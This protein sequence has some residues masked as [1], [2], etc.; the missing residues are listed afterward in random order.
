MFKRRATTPLKKSTNNKCID[1][2][3]RTQPIDGSSRSDHEAIRRRAST[4]DESNDTPSSALPTI[5]DAALSLDECIHISN[6]NRHPDVLELI[7][8]RLSLPDDDDDADDDDS[9]DMPRLSKSSTT[10]SSKPRQVSFLDE[11]L[12]LTPRHLITSIN[13]RPKTSDIEKD[14]LYYT[15]RDFDIFEQ[16]E[17]YERIEN[18][19]QEI[20][21]Q[22]KL[23]GGDA[24]FIVTVKDDMKLRNLIRK[25]E[26]RK[27]WDM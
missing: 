19:I 16:E 1:D 12:G 20:E 15:N 17:L 13:Y 8:K 23:K 9:I 26:R 4:S 22:K 14:S 10:G 24:K 5:E 21:S 7:Q 25:V 2:S 6:R 11:E 3:D 18:E 27:I